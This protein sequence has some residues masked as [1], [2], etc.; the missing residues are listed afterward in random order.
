MP[1]IF[2]NHFNSSGTVQDGE[3]TLTEELGLDV[4]KKVHAGIKHSRMRRSH[5][6]VALG[7]V[8]G[9]SDEVRMLTLKS[10]DRLYSLLW[11]TD[12]AGAAG[13]GD[14]GFYLSGEAN[15]GA[16]PSVNS[17]DC[18]SSTALVIDTTNTR[19]EAFEL[20]DFDTENLGIQVWELIN[21][22]DA[23]TYTVDP[24]VNFDITFTMTQAVT[25]TLTIVQLEAF[26]TSGD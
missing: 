21:V 26:Y 4:G 16:L 8:A 14:L 23:A 6:R 12:G 10:S 9:V 18:F 25:T 1:T 22:S 15:D 13:L 7:T 17:V 3:G 5:A 11:T 19:V 24:N 2:S 20:G